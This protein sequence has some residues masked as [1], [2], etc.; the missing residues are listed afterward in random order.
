MGHWKDDPEMAAYV[1]QKISATKRMVRGDRWSLDFEQ[2]I[3]CGRTD[4]RYG[5]RGRCRRCLLSLAYPA[6][7]QCFADYYQRNRVHAL[8]V[9]KAWRDAHPNYW[10]E[11]WEKKGD[12][13]RCQQRERHANRPDKTAFN[14]EQK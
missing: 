10:N 2:C 8:A 13:L 1:R 5:S 14:R 9:R 12:E 3:L 6:K 7:R 11:R 4:S